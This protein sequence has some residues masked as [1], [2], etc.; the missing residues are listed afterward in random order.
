MPVGLF[1]F[2]HFNFVDGMVSPIS[3]C[4][5]ADD[6]DL[7]GTPGII[8]V[9]VIAGTFRMICEAFEKGEDAFT[10]RPGRTLHLQHLNGD[11]HLV[12]LQGSVL[13]LLPQLVNRNPVVGIFIVQAR[14]DFAAQSGVALMTEM[15]QVS[16]QMILLL[17]RQLC[18]S[19]FDLLQTHWLNYTRPLRFGQAFGRGNA[20]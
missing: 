14:G 13:P 18:Q 15:N 12:R 6:F 20:N 5:I 17:L 7:N 10:F 1:N 19:A 16:R 9:R 4:V 2:R 3:Q 8:A 11:Q